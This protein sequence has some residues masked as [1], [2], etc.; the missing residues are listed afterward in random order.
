MKKH[1]LLFINVLT[2]ASASI[3][4]QSGI[5]RVLESVVSNNKTLQA[6]SRLTETQKLEARTG[7]YLANPTIEFNQLWGNSATGSNV[8]E[9]AVVQSFDFP[10]VYGN[11]NKLVK[12]KTE[13]YD[14]Q[15]AAGRQQILLTAKQTCLEIIYLRKQKKLL[16]N[17][18]KNA[19]QL[20]ELYRQRL[21]NGDAN[22]LELNK[23][24]LEKIN[25]Q[26]ESRLN[27][28]T[29][30]AK[31]EQLQTLNGGQAIEFNDNSY[32]N[33]YPL[34]EFDK[35]QADYLAADPNL[36]SLLN[37]TETANREIKLSKAQNLPKFDLGY[38]R[39]GGNDEKLHGF[40]LG[41][42]IPLWENKN[43]VKKA[44]AQAEY[45][46]AVVEDNTQNL[47]STLR[48]LY[49][50]AEALR[51]SCDEYAKTLSVQHNM[52]LLNKALSAGQISMIDYFVEITIFNSSMQNYLNVE[53][54]YH[55]T[56]AQLL[57]YEL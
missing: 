27:E 14:H 29:L 5:D 19:L 49:T 21:E 13:T 4:A 41:V 3:Y 50:Q 25:A 40:V 43:T 7:N 36:K 9:L 28:A 17:R 32:G 38:R 33:E 48:E 54:E 31:L 55:N 46:G 16:D 26:N 42:S 47:K 12:L 2:L 18:Q 44:K 57:Q 11:K 35:L 24:E 53:K 37:A 51:N 34:P 6:G 20:A 45:A 22:Q 56:L 39:N 23:I 1:I 10:S 52:D 30:R 15:Y 8:N